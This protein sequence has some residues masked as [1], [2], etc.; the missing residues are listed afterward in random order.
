MMPSIYLPRS[1]LAKQQSARAE[2]PRG[3]AVALAYL[4]ANAA[5]W[6]AAG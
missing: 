1:G 4:K 3:R 2:H 6:E 5:A